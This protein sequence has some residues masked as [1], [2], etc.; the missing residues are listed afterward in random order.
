MQL[1]RLMLQNQNIHQLW[2]K[3]HDFF[4]K[5]SRAYFTH[6][7]TKCMRPRCIQKINKQNITSKVKMIIWLD[8]EGGPKGSKGMFKSF[9]TG[10]QRSE[11]MLKIQHLANRTKAGHR[12]S[13]HPNEQISGK[14]WVEAQCYSIGS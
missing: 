11:S 10:V 13:G 2:D 5:V 14:L 8:S 7:I 3:S 9:I 12:P 6:V 1:P 4:D